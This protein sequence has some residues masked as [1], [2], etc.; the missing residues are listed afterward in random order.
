[1]LVNTYQVS[2]FLSCITK[3][4]PVVFVSVPIP[5]LFKKHYYILYFIYLIYVFKDF[6]YYIATGHVD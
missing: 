2:I 3:A 4:I 6:V 5:V 1:M